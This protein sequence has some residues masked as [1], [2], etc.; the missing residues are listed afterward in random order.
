MNASFVV[1]LHGFLSLLLHKLLN[2]AQWHPLKN[3]DGDSEYI[4]K[5]DEL[6]SYSM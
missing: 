1:K 5:T 2:T 6:I 4:K 3:R